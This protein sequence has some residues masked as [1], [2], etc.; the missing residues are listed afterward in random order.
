[1]GKSINFGLTSK[2]RGRS[3]ANRCFLC[4]IEEKSIH[5]LLFHCVKT[6][7]LWELLFAL[8]GVSWVLPSLVRETLLGWH[9]SFVGKK[10]R[11]VWRAG[12][13]CLFW[14]IWKARNRIAFD[15]DEFSIQSLKNSFVC[16]F[17]L[18]AKLLILYIYIYI[19]I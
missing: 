15:R 18:E 11:K 13:L 3:L 2:K 6:R 4:R 16:L 1:M 9:G 7:I 10:N 8:F 12:P 17:W 5:H 14:T 19:Y